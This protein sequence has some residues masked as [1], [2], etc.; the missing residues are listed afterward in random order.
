MRRDQT[1]ARGQDWVEEDTKDREKLH[2]FAEKLE[3][4]SGQGNSAL[5]WEVSGR[6]CERPGIM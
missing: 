5:V 2:S 3:D 4:G 6:G 1:D